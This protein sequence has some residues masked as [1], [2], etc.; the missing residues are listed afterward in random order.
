MN[1]VEFLSFILPS[2]G[3]YFFAAPKP[4]GGYKHTACESPEQLAKLAQGASARGENTFFACSSF[5]QASYQDENGKTKFRTGDNALLARAQWL[6]IDCGEQY[7]GSQKEGLRALVEFCNTTSLPK[8]NVIVNSG[9][10]LHAYWVFDRDVPKAAWR[11]MSAT[12]KAIVAKSGF[13]TDDTSRTADV[14]SVLRPVGTVN[15]KT[16]KGLGVKPVKLLGQPDMAP[17]RVEDWVAHLIRLRQALNVEPLKG[18]KPKVNINSDLGGE[19]EYPASSARTIADHCN[20]IA[21]FREFRGAGQAEPVWHDCVGL[22][23]HC[24]EGAELVHLWSSGHTDYNHADCQQKIDNWNA[25]PTTCLKFKTDNPT[26]CEG[27]KHTVRS[28]IQ[29]GRVAPEHEEE[30]VTVAP[31]GVSTTVTLPE[32]P[33]KV[34]KKFRVHNGALCVQSE[35]KNGVRNWMPFCSSIPYVDAYFYDKEDGQWKFQISTFIRADM[36]RTAT[37]SAGSVGRGGSSLF[38]DLSA[39]AF[40]VAIPGREKHLEAYMKNW[41]EHI[42]ATTDETVMH[43]HMGWYDDGSFVLGHNKHMPDGTIKRVVLLEE[44]R[45]MS[46]AYTPKGELNRYIELLNTAYNRP[47]HQPYQFT[48]LAGFASILLPLM[49]TGSVGIVISGWSNKSGQGKTTACKLAAGIWS[50]PHQVVDAKGTTEFALYRNAGR[51]H[52]VPMV[53]DEVSPWQPP[54]LADFA[55]RYSSG[56]PR[57]QGTPDGG[58]RDNSHISWTN[59]SLVN[60]NKSIHEALS[61]HPGNNTPQIMRVWEYMFDEGVETMDAVSGRKTLDEM[62]RMRGIAGERFLQ[63]VVP[64]REELA[65]MLEKAYARF[66]KLSGSD[67][68]ARYWGMA[69]ACVW[70]AHKVTQSIGMQTFDSAA[71]R[72]WIVVQMQKMGGLALDSV[73]DIDSSFSEMM[74]QLQTGFIVTENEGDLRASGDVCKFAYGY[75]VPRGTVTGRV[76]FSTRKVYVAVSAVRAWC[77]EHAVSMTDMLE[78]LA[79][80]KWLKGKSRQ[81]L[82]KGTAIAIPQ[83]MAL[84]LD[85]HAFAGLVHSIPTEPAAKTEVVE[86]EA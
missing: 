41:I 21:V 64:H 51:R 69:A 58:L 55:Y 18:P 57:E 13:A 20:Q 33:D 12:F 28:P 29:L 86:A 3:V 42:Q 17:I 72:D 50:D 34:K 68:D 10:G 75:S 62:L 81:Y 74:G 83:A 5:A 82:G 8:P 31:T 53:L 61:A 35:D 27:C 56:R 48:W 71:L 16:H 65:E 46:D 44:L 40:I 43:D 78:N 77:T 24:V 59:F 19:A 67:K 38:G 63:Y 6:D 36:M 9:N 73:V 37:I 7:H 26:G 84:E 52:H 11:K 76:I 30:L 2:Q 49:N 80:K 54:A 79:G 85:W 15:N 4:N 32:F 66:M 14:S 47:H 39:K 70:V 23:K 25:G 60:G 45:V 1:T 22:V